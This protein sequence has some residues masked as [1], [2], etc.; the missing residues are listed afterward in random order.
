MYCLCL[1]VYFKLF[2]H[3]ACLSDNRCGVHQGRIQNWRILPS[4][5]QIPPHCRLPQGT[6]NITFLLAKMIALPQGKPPLFYSSMGD[7]GY[8]N[9]SMKGGRS[10]RNCNPPPSFASFPLTPILLNVYPYYEF[11][12]QTLQMTTT[13]S[14]Y[15]HRFFFYIPLWSHYVVFI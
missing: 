15:P 4:C 3:Y 14:T 11:L 10:G 5:S 1:D 13:C 7:F 12:E 2:H 6:C 9:K 8:S